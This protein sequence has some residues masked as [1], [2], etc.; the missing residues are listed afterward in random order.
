VDT[1]LRL[2][3]QEEQVFQGE[4]GTLETTEREGIMQ[5]VTS[6]MEQGIAEGEQRGERRGRTEGEQTGAIR[7]ARSLI[8]RQLTR[9]IGTLP[10]SVEAKVQLL[11]L[12]QLEALGEALLDFAQLGDLTDW[13]TSNS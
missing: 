5:I 7:E 11:M 3:V 6:W 8:L 2:T 4:V 9:R 13:L 10:A 12:H 1:Y